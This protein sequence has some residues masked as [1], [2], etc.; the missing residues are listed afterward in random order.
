M[1]VPMSRI[2]LICL[3]SIRSALVESLQGQGLLHVQEVPLENEAAPDFLCRVQLQGEA[4]E[5]WVLL[6]EMERTLNEVVPLLTQQPND[7]SVRAGRDEIASW[8]NAKIAE[9]VRAWADELRSLTRERTQNQDAIDILT[10]YEGILENVA[11][12]LGG[13]SARL[14]KSTR[15]LVLTGNVS[16]VVARLD[17]RFSEEIGPECS[18]HTNQVSRKQ[19]V[20][21]VACPES[22]QEVLVRIL[23]QEGV[24]PVDMSDHADEGASIGETIA[25]I[26]KTIEMHRAN[27]LKLEGQA[28]TAAA[29][30][31]AHLCAIRIFTGEVLARL[32]VQ[33][34]FAQSE[35]ITVIHGWT[36]TES[37]A[38]LERA[39]EL[40]FPGQVEV[41]RI[42]PDENPRESIPTLLKNPPLFKPF[43]VI[44]K[45]FDPPRYGTVDPTIMIAISFILFYGFIV[46]D[47]VYGVAIILFAKWMGRKWKH[48]P[49]VVAASTIGMYM[50]ISTMVFGVLYG[51]YAGEIFGIPHV[52]FHRGHEQIELLVYALYLGIVHILLAIGLGIYEGFRHGHKDHAVEKI[53]MLLGVLGLII[54]SFGFFGVSPFD[55]QFMLVLAGVMILVG[56]VLIIK[57]LGPMMGTVGVLEIM[58]LGGNII[59]YARLMALGL[60]AIAIADIANGLP[61]SFGPWIGV[62]A[63]I[64]V[65]LMNIGISLASPTIHALRLNFVE[66]LPKF[67]E[68]DGR[69]FKPFKKETV[70]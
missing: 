29:E 68:A 16:E 6:E 20:G 59:S 51:E 9:K 48:I 54:I 31:G 8:D 30:S 58:S 46:G 62:P 63:A 25:R 50:G 18:F 56:A 43:E 34:Q 37:F 52:W 12:A 19:V 39:I 55:A 45:L 4:H 69:D 15:A 1:I 7:T 40:E 28:N 65:H 21:L 33:G 60:A 10:N 27:L 2:E 41:N 22:K 14:T 35:M 61:G 13:K 11:P 24:A 44:L 67:Y 53:G 5:D 32:R 47:F 42:A 57:T 64:M 66:F 17:A 38:D 3:T 36:P 70:R 49:E 26:K 23:N